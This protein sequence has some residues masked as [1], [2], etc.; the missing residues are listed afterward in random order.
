MLVAT[1]H[2]RNGILLSASTANAV[3]ALVAGEPVRAEW[4]PFDVHRFRA[5][6]RPTPEAPDQK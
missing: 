3:T 2:Y 6:P 4:K 1:G 5:E